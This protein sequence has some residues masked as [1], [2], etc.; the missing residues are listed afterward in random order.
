MAEFAVEIDGVTF[1]YPGA[2]TPA[3]EGVSLRVAPGERLGILGPNG[4]GKS[5]LLKI[6]L[7]LLQ[8]G[9]GTV[10]VLGR[11]PAQARREGLIGY[12]AQRPNLEL[13]L[14]LSV[15]E[16]VLLGG[17]WRSAPWRPPPR[18]SREH[19]ARMIDL[20]GA[21]EFAD[22]PIGRLSGGQLQRALIARALAADAKI[23]ALDEPTVGIDAAGQ[24]RFAELLDRVHRELGLTILTI[25]HDLRAI[26]AG[27]DRVAC[28]AC[29]LHSHTSPTG[30]TPQILAELFTHDVA[31]LAG[32]GGALSGMHVHA[33]AAGEPCSEAHAPG[34]PPVPV[35]LGVPGSRSG[36]AGREGRSG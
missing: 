29:R 28:L 25:T 27:S 15:R 26:V 33:H 22:R 7:G 8:P 1:T 32:L 20:V 23:L 5:T 35:N 12:V 18:S 11:S 14:P 19:A 9:S 4:G 36:S 2:E 21:G 10:R 16:A 24:A 31:G 6:V 30:L 17:A 13:R 3:L 34:G